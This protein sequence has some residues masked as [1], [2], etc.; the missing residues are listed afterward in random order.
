[1]SVPVGIDKVDIG[2]DFHVGL[3]AIV[4]T[5]T[6]EQSKVTI[7]EEDQKQRPLLGS[8]Q[9]YLQGE[10]K[11]SIEPFDDHSPTITVCRISTLTKGR[12]HH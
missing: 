7:V 10:A 2:D 3:F 5:I 11:G 9:Y 6:L 8:I 4:D 12:P 1:M